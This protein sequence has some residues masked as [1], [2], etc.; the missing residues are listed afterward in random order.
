M[1]KVDQDVAQVL[2]D[3]GER[4]ALA[5]LMEHPPRLAVRAQRL[6][7]TAHGP[8][9]R[10][11]VVGLLGRLELVALFQEEATALLRQ[12]DRFLVASQVAQAGHVAN[13]GPG[14]LRAQAKR[15]E[16]RLGLLILGDRRLIPSQ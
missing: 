15:L 14:C 11:Q 13:P 4:R 10:T 8:V 5:E 7:E 16:A 1:T 9:D 6:A 3:V 2:L 12:S